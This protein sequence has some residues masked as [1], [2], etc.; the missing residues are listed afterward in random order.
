MGLS[1]AAI[2]AT[3]RPSVVNEITA[4]LSLLEIFF[5][6]R[7]IRLYLPWPFRRAACPSFEFEDT[8]LV[9]R[10]SGRSGRWSHGSGS[11]AV[12]KAHGGF[13]GEMPGD[14][15][16]RQDGFSQADDCLPAAF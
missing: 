11:R 5:Q 16:Y 10:L 1:R 8:I 12:R 9:T 2:L 6:S 14:P 4:S 7:P 15:G 3:S 13:G